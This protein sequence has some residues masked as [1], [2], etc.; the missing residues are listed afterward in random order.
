MDKLLK[1]FNNFLLISKCD[2]NKKDE[3]EEESE[4]EDNEDEA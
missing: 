3:E 1:V 2:E 4:Q